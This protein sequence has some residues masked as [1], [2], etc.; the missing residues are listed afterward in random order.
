[1]VRSLLVL[2]ILAALLISG[3]GGSGT[4]T[5]GSTLTS[6]SIASRIDF[7]VSGGF[8]GV[9]QELVIAPDGRATVT[10]RFRDTS[11]A[12][13]FQLSDAQLSELRDKLAAAGIA[14]LPIPPPSG[15]ADCFIYSIGFEGR[16]YRT[17][18]ASVPKPL[19]PAI[20]ELAQ[21][22]SAHN[23]GRAPSLSGK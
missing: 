15:C 3:C 1:V 6:T 14:Q 17:D 23:A 10:T 5:S 18:Q 7:H 20:A 16:S 19:E 2:G 8:A 4:S 11:S 9:D 21:L 22:V 13:H 12:R